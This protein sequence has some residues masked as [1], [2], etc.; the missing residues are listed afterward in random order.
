MN[1]NKEHISLGFLNLNKTSASKNLMTI[2]S[3]VKEKIKFQNSQ[4]FDSQEIKPYLQNEIYFKNFLSQFDNSKKNLHLKPTHK[5]IS[6]NLNS[7][8]NYD[9]K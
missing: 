1:K 9:K 5:K 7:V 8:S 4:K 6:S 2:E 3:K